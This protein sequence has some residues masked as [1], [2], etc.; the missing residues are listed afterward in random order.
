MTHLT[1]YKK[2]LLYG[3]RHAAV[4]QNNWTK[5]YEVVQDPK[6]SPGAFLQ[7]IRDTIR[8][9]T[10]AD[11]ND[12]QT[13][14]IIKGVFTSMA[15]PDIKRKLQKK[16]DLMGMTMAQILEAAN[17]VYSL[18]EVEKEKKQVRLMVAAVQAGTKGSEQE[19]RGRGRGRPGLRER[20]LGRNQCA[21]CRQEGHWK[22]EYPNKKERGGYLYDGDRRTGIGVSGE[23]DHPT[24]GTPSKNAGEK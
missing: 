14:A 12:P 15:V 16:E 9:Y 21:L 19:G 2:L 22:N 23:T 20:R 7:R 1:T 10:N 24:P 6:E 18:R 11:P 5:L 3:I 13:E 8:Q 4:R 17:R